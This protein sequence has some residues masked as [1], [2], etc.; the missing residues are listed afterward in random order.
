MLRHSLASL[1]ADLGLPDHTISG[2]LKHAR[3]GTTSRYLHL[4]DRARLDAADFVA[5]ETKRLMRQGAA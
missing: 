2:L 4:A 3:Q 1:A 5:G